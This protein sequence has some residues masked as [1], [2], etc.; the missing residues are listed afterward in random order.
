MSTVLAPT[1]DLPPLLSCRGPL[2]R[3]LVFGSVGDRGQA[4]TSWF[5][6]D[7]EMPRDYEVAVGY[8]GGDPAG[9]WARFLANH[10]DHF[11]VHRGGK[12]QNLLWWVNQ[13]S[14]DSGGPGV[15][16]AF[17]YVIVADDDI[18]L[19]SDMIG[20]MV[21]TA[22]EYDL[23]V[24]SPSHSWDGRI[25]WPHMGAR[26][27]GKRAHEPAAGVEF[28]NFVEMTC[29]VFEVDAL[30]RFLGLFQR[31]ADRLTGWGADWLISCACFT[32]QRPFG[33]MHNVTITN[34]RT[35]PGRTPN[36]REIDTL[37]PARQ[38]QQNWL[39]IAASEKLAYTG[40]K[41]LRTWLPQPRMRCINL[42]RAT[43]RRERFTRDWIEGAG[44]PVR[45]FTAIDRRDIENGQ[46]VFS[47][48]EAAARS[49]IGRY[50]TSGE[51][52]C[53]TSHALVVREE[54]EFCGPEGVF[55]MEDDCYPILETGAERIVHRVR[56]A[57]TA[58][59]GIEVVAGLE[60][61][62]R[63][64][65][66]EEAGGAMRILDPPW[67]SSV[68]WYSPHGLR[69]AYELLSRMDC[70]ADWIWKDFSATGA[71]AMLKPPIALHNVTDTTYI[72]NEFR[73]IRRRFIP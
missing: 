44:F 55:I 42:E 50:M 48:D 52:A 29:P 56:D 43:E 59:P 19:T 60:P 16:D 58:L 5:G 12:F 23:P 45:F 66:R 9:P 14:G 21:R 25:S 8:Y 67:G 11:Q 26:G 69:R 17:D 53:A 71:F 22:R 49:R 4:V 62:T 54:L 61:Y 64:T 24:A 39:S 37:E 68:T 18:A 40:P 51:I 32:E 41:D 1:V 72:G 3:T 70:P 15:L 30:R 36:L 13:H 6:L 46:M 57:V 47:Y 2:P 38:R 31:Y 33:V 10:A 63:F 7:S 20:R 65:V 73:G 27:S 35:R 34:P 28:C